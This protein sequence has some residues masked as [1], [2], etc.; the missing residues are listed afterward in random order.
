MFS[1]RLDAEL[2][3]ERLN[4]PCDIRAMTDP[5][6]CLLRENTG[7]TGLERTARA[8]AEILAHFDIPLDLL[9]AGRVL[10]R[11]CKV[12]FPEPA[13]VSDKPQIV[14]LEDLLSLKLDSWSVSPTR[15]VQDK[16]DVVELIKHRRLPRNLAVLDVVQ[17]LYLEIWDALQAEK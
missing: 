17:P 13:R 12:P 1:D 10:R 5:A 16:A 11:G 7:T 9:P 14:G 8:A 15:R 2:A 3:V 6:A 4:R